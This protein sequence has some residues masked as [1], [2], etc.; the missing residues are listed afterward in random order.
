[1]N[2][3]NF[4]RAFTAAALLFAVNANAQ[5]S[6]SG[7]ILSNE[8]E[9]VAFATVGIKNTQLATVADGEGK[10]S[11]RNLKNDTYV[12]S[13]Q[14][15]GY[16]SN[17]VVAEV[18]G[19][20]QLGIIALTKSNKQLDEVIVNS[21]R[22][23]KNSGMAFSNVDTE[24]LKKQNFGQDAPYMLNQLPSVVINSDAGN[25][26]GYTGMRIRGSDGTRINV[27]INGVPVN[28]A[29]S[30][31]TFFVNM[32]DLVS[33]VNNIQVQRGV[34]ASSNGAG[35]FGASVNF[36][37]NQLNEKPYANVISTA[38]SY[39]TFRNTLAAGTG[40]LNDKFTLD[41][42]ASKITSN[43]YIDR[44]ASDLQSYYLA[45]GYY[46]KKSVIKFINFLGQEKTY[47]AWNYVP[48]D[49][50]RAGNRTYNELGAYY[51]TNGK[52]KYYNNQTDNYKQNNF[53]LH[54]IHQFNS[55]VSLNVTGHYTKGQG[56]YEEYKPFA[57]FSSYNIPDV[58]SPKGDTINS[59]DLIR[60]KWLDND[61]AGGIFNFKY[62][63][64]QKLNFILG[65]GYNTYFG[66]HF[67]RV[68]WAQ[69]SSTI[70]TEHE[71]YYN[72]ANKNDG[73]LYLK[74]NYSPIKRLN[75]FLDL[76]AR[77][78]DYRFLGF[79]NLF[80]EKMQNKSYTFFNPKLGLSYDVN[81]NTNVY[82]SFAMANKEP[83][84]NDFVQSTPQ[85]RPKHEQLQDVE[86]GIKQSYKRLEWSANFYN[87]QYKN[88][89]VLNGEIN[90]VG[91][92][93]RVNVESSFRRGIE[94]EANVALNN[95][96]SLGG[97]VTLSQ[98]KIKD[99]I[100]YIDSS[101][102]NTNGE[103]MYT[104]YKNVYKNTDISF[105][106]NVV[107]ALMFT[108]KPV[109]GLEI[110]FIN[111]YI[112]RQFLDNTSN[113]NRSINPYNVLNA[114]VN[115]SIKTKLIPE[116]GLMLSVN[117]LLNTKY[118][119]NGWTYSYYYDSDKISTINYLAP[120]ALLNFMVGVNLKF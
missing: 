58:I 82:A 49:S 62:I 100:E 51:D 52:L 7:Q 67:G 87:M 17:T 24:T 92:N 110:T 30:Q 19:E 11:F 80:E 38:G 47:Q 70:D 37:T 85:S 15:L 13:I 25:G 69:Q 115:Y 90:D 73:N 104:Q 65:G 6:L 101:Y 64:N 111:K 68:I 116:I 28:D 40:L 27:T 98:N 75:V 5:S 109:K 59:S 106:P 117:N 35:A 44:A 103:E 79:D 23:D 9:P 84:R 4:A 119:T 46:G 26:V 97:N 95:Y 50:V 81:A 60:R 57:N 66:K 53:Q 120:A 107:S 34:G 10:F 105:S 112:G 32:S 74:T 99:F 91:A 114:Q 78:V 71:Y 113:K 55:R 56:Y 118:E 102:V 33:S 42:R 1:M 20:T 76:Q 2:K 96:F 94:L 108:I 88:Q 72:T 31:G 45:G 63:V 93:N 48:E 86:A 14:C 21:T 83:N 54:F 41:A 18:N 77:Y 12:L 22:V 36:Q 61:F 43:G 29:E 16:L 39:N 89:L 8:Q 3:Q